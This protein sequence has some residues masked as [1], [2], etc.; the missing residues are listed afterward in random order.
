M[1]PTEIAMNFKRQYFAERT[2]LSRPG[3]GATLVLAL[4]LLI[5]TVT[6]L[7]DDAPVEVINPTVE[8]RGLLQ[9]IEDTSITFRV[10]NQIEFNKEVS[11]QADINVT[12]VNGIVLLSGSVAT[13]E[14]KQWCEDTAKSH[15]KVQKVIN[16][17]KVREYRSALAIA[18]D[19]GIQAAVKFRLVNALDKQS[20]TVHVVVYDKVAYLMCV[21]SES[22]AKRATEVAR[23]VKFVERVITIIQFKEEHETER[24]ESIS[25]LSCFLDSD[26]QAA[27]STV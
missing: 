27:E 13:A 26:C 22:V 24:S 3:F 15:P 7:A 1:L 4:G 9:K 18:R 19:K 2:A 23:Q 17:L 8:R 11:D 6:L 5:P 20:P 14:D 21:V 16:E 12:T 25:S 10:S